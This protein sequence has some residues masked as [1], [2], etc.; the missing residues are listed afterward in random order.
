MTYA[1]EHQEQEQHGRSGHTTSC[2]PVASVW[3]AVLGVLLVLVDAAVSR[4]VR[5]QRVVRY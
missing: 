1:D 3:R 4:S 5:G 2:I